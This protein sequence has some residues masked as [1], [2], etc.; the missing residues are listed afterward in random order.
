MWGILNAYHFDPAPD[1]YQED[2]NRLIRGFSQSAF[3]G[4]Y[5]REYKIAFGEWPVTFDECAV[6]LITG[7]SKGAYEDQPWILRLQDFITGL[8]AR[9]RKLI[10]ICFGHQIVAQALGGRVE[11]SPK[12]WGVGVRDFS[13]VEPAKWMRPALFRLSMLFSHQDQVV[14]PPPGACLLASDEFCPYQMLQ[15]DNHILTLQGHPEFSVEFARA[16]L[17]SRREKMPAETYSRAL[18]SLS[19]PTDHAVIGGWLREFAKI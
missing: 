10:G 6:W 16:R 2:Y 17:E 5:V 15:L 19:R 9:R 3:P 8:H 4:E 7:S 13:I 11:K 18:A 12:G 1:S 14:E